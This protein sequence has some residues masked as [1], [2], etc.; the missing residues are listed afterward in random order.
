MMTSDRKLMLLIVALEKDIKLQSK[1]DLTAYR[2][3]MLFYIKVIKV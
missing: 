3:G 2:V 1:T